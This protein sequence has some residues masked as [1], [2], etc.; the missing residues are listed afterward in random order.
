M[1]ELSAVT[2]RV[3]VHLQSNSFPFKLKGSEIGCLKTASRVVKQLLLRQALPGG[4]RNVGGGFN[5]LS[6][7]TNLWS[8]AESSATEAWKRNLNYSNAQVNRNNNNK[9]YG[10]SGRC[11]KDWRT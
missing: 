3:S 8:A 5:N 11:C 10:F 4:N 9:A 1:P 2:A 7:N 6:N